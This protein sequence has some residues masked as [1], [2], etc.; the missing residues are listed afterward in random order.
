MCVVIQRFADG[1]FEPQIFMPEPFEFRQIFL[2]LDERGFI[3]LRFE[4]FDFDF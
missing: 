3:A 2:S 4:S 1:Y